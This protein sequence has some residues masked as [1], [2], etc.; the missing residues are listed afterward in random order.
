MLE[1]NKIKPLFSIQEFKIRLKE[2]KN[3]NNRKNNNNKNNKA[4]KKH[5]NFIFTITEN[6]KK[7][8]YFLSNKNNIDLCDNIFQNKQAFNYNYNDENDLNKYPIN[9]KFKNL[10]YNSRNKNSNLKTKNKISY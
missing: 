4:K 7:L 10:Y 3:F 6:E 8:S 5:K 9:M 2:S 1:I